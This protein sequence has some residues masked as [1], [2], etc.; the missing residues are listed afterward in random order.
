MAGLFICYRR[1]LNSGDAA[2]ISQDLRFYIA[3]QSI[4]RDKDSVPAGLNYSTAISRSLSTCSV[5]LVIIGPK[6]LSE[7]NVTDAHDNDS[8]I[9]RVFRQIRS[10]LNRKNDNRIIPVLVG[11]ATIPKLSELPENLADLVHRKPIRLRENQWRKDIRQLSTLLLKCRGIHHQRNE[12]PVSARLQLGKMRIDYCQE[13][14][15]TRV[16]NRDYT[17]V[18]LYIESGMKLDLD[19]N[20]FGLEFSREEGRPKSAIEIAA[21]NN[22][23]DMVSLLVKAGADINPA[24]PLVTGCDATQEELLTKLLSLNPRPDA[25]DD[26]FV[27]SISNCNVKAAKKLYS[28]GVSD[29]GFQQAVFMA[30]RNKN[31]ES[32]RYLL[33][34]RIIEPNL[35]SQILL[36]IVTY[37]YKNNEQDTMHERLTIY[38]MLMDLGAD[39]NWIENSNSKTAFQQCVSNNATITFDFFLESG[40]NINHINKEMRGETLLKMAAYS[41]LTDMAKRLLDKG[42][43]PSLCS[44]GETPL[45]FAVKFGRVSIVKLLLKYQAEINTT[46]EGRSLMYYADTVEVAELLFNAGLM[47][48]DGINRFFKNDLPRKDALELLKFYLAKGADPNLTDT[49]GTTLLMWAARINKLMWARILIQAG[50]SIDNRDNYGRCALD[51][52]IPNHHS[53]IV[54]LLSSG[55]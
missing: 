34:L 46:I 51:F 33:E 35:A 38:R 29:S 2:R 17:I 5:L 4:F 20:G 28:I 40:A 43:N 21:T 48:N 39:P 16:K 32:L 24:L 19:N 11:N 26:A 54:K 42:A 44:D 45:F 27:S 13:D 14:F 10:V 25:V 7:N 30:A 22:D 55:L 15:L 47:V 31:A 18:K 23:E 52:A 12:S 9:N 36:L 8:E 6:W 49:E 41:G 53:E 37:T 50:A 1:D 3:D